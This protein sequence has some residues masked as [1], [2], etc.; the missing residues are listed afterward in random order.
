MRYFL[1]LSLSLAVTAL[2]IRV[3]KPPTTAGL[4]L[5]CRAAARFSAGHY[6]ARRATVDI[7]AIAV[8]ADNH[9]AMAAGAVIQTSTGCHRQIGR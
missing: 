4:V 1:S 9:L 3:A 6:R 2:T 8:A 5:G 7:A